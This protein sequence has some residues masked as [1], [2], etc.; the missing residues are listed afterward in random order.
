MNSFYK[1]RLLLI[2]AVMSFFI[3]IASQ[4]P[5]HTKSLSLSQKNINLVQKYYTWIYVFNLY[6]ALIYVYVAFGMKCS[7]TLVH[8]LLFWP[9]IMAT[10]TTI[11]VKYFLFWME[12]NFCSEDVILISLCVYWCTLL[13]VNGSE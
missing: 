11:F 7:E 1:I 5:A 13:F 10:E 9:R 4:L 8:I 2:I 6:I 12:I 3:Y